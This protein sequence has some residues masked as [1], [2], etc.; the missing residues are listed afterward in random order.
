MVE[1]RT[2]RQG[3]GA[4]LQRTGRP[5]SRFMDMDDASF[6]GSFAE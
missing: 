3:G 6:A 1:T 4:P 2:F 5:S